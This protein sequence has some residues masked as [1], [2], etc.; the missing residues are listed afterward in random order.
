MME[1][2]YIVRSPENVLAEI[3]YL[4]DKFG[5][6]GI[7][8][9]DWEFVINKART[10]EICDLIIKEGLDI[11]WGCNA[12]VADI[13]DEVA[14][15]MK[16]AGCVRVNIGFESGSQKVL[17]ILNKRITLEETKNCVEVLRKH[18]IIIGLYAI[19]NLPGEDRSSI[20]ETEKFLSDNDL[21]TMCEPNLPI[22]YF[23]TEMYEMLK[24][25]EGKEFDW[26]NLEK[27]AG[28]VNVNQPPWLARI[29]RWHYKYTFSKGRFYFISPSIFSKVVKKVKSKLS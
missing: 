12:R 6:K 10:I 4:I 13:D 19:L 23:S 21:E 24:K 3:K 29:Y 1:R 18:E 8:F 7:Y 14:Q 28:R 20:K 25:Q 27:F 9:Q 26:Q 11:K 22:P 16:Q 2:F 17:D 5:V 15:K